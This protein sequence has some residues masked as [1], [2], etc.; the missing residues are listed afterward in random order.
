MN[1]KIITNADSI[2]NIHAFDEAWFEAQFDTEE[3]KQEWL[4]SEPHEIP[5]LPLANDVATK[6]NS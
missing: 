4:N 5:S 6:P 2:A 3:E 1:P